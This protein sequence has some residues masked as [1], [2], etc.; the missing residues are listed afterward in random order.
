MSTREERILDA[1]RVRLA[2]I[3]GIA[4]V[5]IDP[6]AEF[7]DAGPFPNIAIIPDDTVPLDGDL[8]QI[9]MVQMPLTVRGL[10]QTE[11]AA[12]GVGDVPNSPRTAGYRLWK[13]MLAAIF[14]G[15]LDAEGVY[16][17]RLDGQLVHIR[18]AGHSVQPHD[19]GG[20]TFGVY[21]GLEIEYVLH[22]NDPDK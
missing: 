4:S 6:P 5:E 12:P 10:T 18:Y 3:S 14:L 13:Q 2:A 7:G 8:P 19:D 17:D 15:P 9:R 21:L 11:A 1:L 16:H 22:L 20:K